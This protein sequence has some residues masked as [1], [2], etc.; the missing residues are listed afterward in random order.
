MIRILLNLFYLLTTFSLFSQVDDLTPPGTWQ[1]LQVSN[2]IHPDD[3]LIVA[4]DSD[5]LLSFYQLV[6]KPNADSIQ[7]STI[8]FEAA[9]PYEGIY[10]L[11]GV[12]RTNGD[13]YS[14]YYGLDTAGVSHILQ[15]SLLN[16]TI[17][18]VDTDRNWFPFIPMSTMSDETL[19]GALNDID[20][21][22]FFPVVLSQD[23]LIPLVNEGFEFLLSFS[24]DTTSRVYVTYIGASGESYLGYYDITHGFMTTNIPAT[25]FE[26][27]S[28]NP[29]DDLHT[30]VTNE[31][32]EGIA[33][34]YKVND[35]TF[36][37]V[38]IPG[39]PHKNISRLYRNDDTQTTLFSIEDSTGVVRLV[40]RVA[41]DWSSLNSQLSH[42]DPN[43]ITMKASFEHDVFIEVDEDGFGRHIYNFQSYQSGDTL[44]DVTPS[45]DKYSFIKVINEETDY[46]LVLQY[47]GAQGDYLYDYFYGSF[48][49]I[50]PPSSLVNSSGGAALDIAYEGQGVYEF[51]ERNIADS[52]NVQYL[53]HRPSFG[54][55]L[56]PI[57]VKDNVV[58]I[59]TCALADEV[60][61]EENY[62]DGSTQFY[63]YNITTQV[64]SVLDL[65]LVAE[66]DEVLI[67]DYDDIC[68]L[69]VNTEENPDSV[70]R[71]FVT[72]QGNATVVDVTHPQY[73]FKE[74]A[75]EGEEGFDQ[76][77]LA[78]MQARDNPND[79]KLWLITSE[80]R[81][82][83]VCNNTYKFFYD[84]LTNTNIGSV[85][86]KQ[87]IIGNEIT[88][89]V[90]GGS[91]SFRAEEFIEFL[92]EA[93]IQNGAI[94]EWR[95]EGCSDR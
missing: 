13:D 81:N 37:E 5:S 11:G 52:R 84:P 89:S 34:L 88:Q 74:I 77:V 23:T 14:F 26:V 63:N 73:Q 21:G 53:Y 51:Q 90:N 68:I 22:T 87:H 8:F 35:T 66:K 6:R 60:I 80:P 49:N 75:G 32:N 45:G 28:D 7:G 44:F 58:D 33:Q 56:D 31:F 25:S 83:E 65:P 76:G 47:Q 93:S 4:M 64:V 18:E 78:V 46:P 94:A 12:R 92:P 9:I 1:D 61:F 42:G 69:V 36:T 70:S 72:V 50:P 91:L 82:N 54:S 85:S 19:F 3:A 95:I 86:A 57:S 41:G 71:L 15:V 67:Y 43:S 38:I 55:E 48:A 79:Q 17:E 2:F 20:A 29:G 27:I 40:K 16:N 24:T 10:P 62:I 59:E 30:I 39:A